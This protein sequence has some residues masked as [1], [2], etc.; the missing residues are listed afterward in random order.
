MAAFS[1][2][3]AV[4]FKETD[5][6]TI[7][8]A[9]ATTT[10]AFVGTFAWGPVMDVT[11]ISDEGAL[12]TRF[13]KPTNNTFA[14]FFS[15]ANFLAYSNDL[16]VIR[17][18]ATGLVN[19]VSSG[20]AVKIKN[21]DDY[22]N[23]YANGEGSVGMFAAKYPGAVG[24]SLK[25]SIADAAT[26]SRTLTGTV[27]VSSGSAVVTGDANT[28]F[29][30]EL[31][32]GEW[33]TI[34]AGGTTYEKQVVTITSASSVT[35]DSTFG[36]SASGLTA[37]A[38]WEYYS[39]FD[40]APVDS[41]RALEAGAS[42]DG[43]HMVIVDEDA[44]FTGTKGYVLAKY[45]NLSKASNGMRY[46]GTSGYYKNVLNQSAY[47]WWM[48]HPVSGQL[49]A[50]GLEWGTVTTT[51]AYKSLKTSLSNSLVGGVDDFTVTDGNLQLAWD[52]FGNS[53]KYDVSLLFTGKVSTT[54][55]AY[56]INNIASVRMDCIAFVSPND[57]GAPIIG[58]T[59][60]AI[61]KILAFRTALNLSS[62]YGVMDSGYKYQ[63][64]KYNDV[65]RW[66]PM[67]ADVAG[68]CAYT[69]L[70]ADPWYSPGGL[71]RGQIK[72][73]TKLAVNPNKA[74]RDELFKVGVNPIVSFPG[75]G[76]V[77]FGDK[78]LLSRPS[79]FDAINV[80]R[81]FIVL[82]KAIATASKYFLFELNNDLTRQL[83]AGML[84][85]Y[86][87]NIQGRQGITD[88]LVD[89]GPTVNTQEVIDSQELRANIFIKPARSIR[90]I[91]LNFV[92]V[93][94]GASFTELE[95]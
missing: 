13:G 84:N 9:V 87:R 29:T 73:V 16:K 75:Q 23:S 12:V 72:G 89:V 48:D 47:V 33:V 64:D 2:S 3:P 32:V 31:A 80:R 86:L 49:E 70:A 90:T 24:N 5:L 39:L 79:A 46:D 93:R 65:Y 52:I 56:V 74:Q 40:G 50:S 30:T 94:S 91:L 22:D 78:T 51:G 92:A 37:V 15:A 18:D 57:N 85:P 77:L 4:G 58:D 10:G 14:S 21:Q 35:L 44:L 63:Y 60:E 55:S 76:T 41:N 42:D 68:V 26:F 67:N 28:L 69:D 20:T 62:S 83:F 61:E 45:D 36:A 1:I 19:A 43:L 6:T 54:V 34:T 8:P 88:F 66:I 17:A 71:N 11:G 95:V 81:L 27:S 82:E 25:V 38:K 59:S 7:I 53:E